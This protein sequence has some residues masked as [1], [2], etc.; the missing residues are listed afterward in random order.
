[1]FQKL[2]LDLSSPGNIWIYGGDTD[3]AGDCRLRFPLLPSA[4]RVHRK[5]GFS[6]M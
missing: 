5:T 1:M 2:P 6:L 3:G 4:Y